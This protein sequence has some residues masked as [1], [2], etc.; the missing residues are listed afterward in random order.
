MPA[1]TINIP[2]VGDVDFPDTMS[3]QE[4]EQAISLQPKVFTAPGQI[5]KPITSPNLE[6]VPSPLKAAPAA[7]SISGGLLGGPV[8]ALAG[9]F[10]GYGLKNLDPQSFGEPPSAVE[11]GVDTAFNFLPLEKILAGGPKQM[12]SKFL[13]KT[14]FAFPAVKQ[15]E[16]KDAAQQFAKGIEGFRSSEVDQLTKAAQGASELR[17]ELGLKLENIKKPIVDMPTGLSTNERLLNSIANRSGE[18]F[19]R[20]QTPSIPQIIKSQKEPIET[21]IAKK[22]G[23]NPVA[24]ELLDLNEQLSKGGAGTVEFGKLANKVLSDV[25]HVR[26]LKMVA[27]PEVAES[28]ALNRAV[29]KGISNKTQAIQ[30][31]M[32]LSELNGEARDIYLEA[33]GKDRLKEVTSFLNQLKSLEDAIPTKQPGV[34][35]YTKNRLIFNIGTGIAT[36]SIFG[37]TAGSIVTGGLSAIVFGEAAVNHLLKNPAAQKMV[38]TAIKT[39]KDLPEA[40][41]IAKALASSLRGI[42]VYANTREGKVKGTL[43]E[44]GEFIPNR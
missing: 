23:E 38:L 43:N 8:G 15:L 16:A 37:A 20:K 25:T 33:I 28:L 6:G 14:K 26:N 7:L 19:V 34:V 39:P 4:I 3:D 18:D 29:I 31:D 44:N 17:K 36:G 1:K 32:I 21:E 30:P 35:E 13:A 9:N 12:L 40:G 10:L 41:F 27:G 22:F 5:E 42:E 2:G 24:A 11:A